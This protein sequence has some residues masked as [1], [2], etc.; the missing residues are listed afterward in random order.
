MV[1]GLHAVFYRSNGELAMKKSRDKISLWKR[2]RN[3]IDIMG[4]IQRI[5]AQPSVFE[6]SL[7]TPL[8]DLLKR[9]ALTDAEL[10][11]SDHVRVDRGRL[12]R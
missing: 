12:P 8:H 11:L 1:A 4:H 6:A 10:I 9:R 2:K 5:L 3:H 7:R